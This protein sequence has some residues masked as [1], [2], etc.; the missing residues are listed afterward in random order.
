MDNQIA[1]EGYDFLRKDRAATQNKS[2]GGL[3]FYFRK[4]LT[5]LRRAEFEISK[6]ETL[7]A[8]IK[9]PN[10][11]PFLVC[12]VYRPP[13]ARSEWADLFEEEISIAQTTGL[14]YIVMCDFNIDLLSD[15]SNTKWSNMIQLLDLTQLISKPAR[16]MQTTT[17]LI[18]H[19]YTT[20]PATISESFVLDLSVS[21][22]FLVCIT[23][24][25]SNKCPKMTTLPPL[26]AH[27][28]TLMNNSSYMSLL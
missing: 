1:I 11:R 3:V 10:S 12:T 17:T 22:H 15:K 27:S 16:V 9:L 21:D 2:G 18:Y 20:A 4:S 6:L 28:K 24:K 5:C 8:E 13:N 23:Q 26:I 19:V 7:W 25:V 14:E